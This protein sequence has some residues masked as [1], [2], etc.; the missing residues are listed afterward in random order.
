[1]AASKKD[2]EKGPSVAATVMGE[3]KDRA[4]QRVQAGKVETRTPI[5]ALQKWGATRL[6]GCPAAGDVINKRGQSRLH[7]MHSNFLEHISTSVDC[8]TAF[9]R[10]TPVDST[11]TALD[12]RHCA[13]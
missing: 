6:R 7:A 1:M 12:V 11:Q 5:S 8:M 4:M 10:Y 13:T 9:I 2:T 3:R